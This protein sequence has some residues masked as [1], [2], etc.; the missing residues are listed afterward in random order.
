MLFIVSLNEIVLKRYEE[1]NENNV[2]VCA[3]GKK[4]QIYK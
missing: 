2:I 3:F 4:R 1:G